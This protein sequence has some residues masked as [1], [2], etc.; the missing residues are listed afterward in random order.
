MHVMKRLAQFTIQTKE[1]IH[2]LFHMQGEV[3]QSQLA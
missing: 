2:I 1:E 3:F